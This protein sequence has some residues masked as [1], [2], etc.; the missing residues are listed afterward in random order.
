MKMGF[1][2]KNVFTMIHGK[3]R[4]L[5]F[6]YFANEYNRLSLYPDA[7]KI[8]EKYDIHIRKPYNWPPFH[9]PL[10]FVQFGSKDF[11]K[12][13]F[14]DYY[15]KL[16]NFLND[17][18][19]IESGEKMSNEYWENYNPFNKEEIVED[20]KKTLGYHER[21]K[22][23]YAIQN[24][25]IV[26]EEETLS[27][28]KIDFVGRFTVPLVVFRTMPKGNS[29]K[30]DVVIAIHGK[31]SGPDYV[32]GLTDQIDYTRA[33]GQYWAHKGHIVYAPQVN[34]DA[35]GLSMA[36]LG[37]SSIG[38]DL[39]V[40][41][42][43]ISMIRE[44]HGRNTSILV[45]GISYGAFLAELLGILSDDVQT[46]ISIGGS[47]RDTK[48]AKWLRGES[49]LDPTNNIG[50]F[51]NSLPVRY[52]FIY[53]PHVYQLLAPKPLVLSIGSHDY[54][55]YKF[56]KMPEV[57][58]YYQSI[59]FGD[60]IRINLFLGFHEA[61]PEGEYLAFEKLPVARD[62]TTSLRQGVFSAESQR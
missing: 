5:Y 39:S 57:V 35:E 20:L 8:L 43:L 31:A 38:A 1:F 62:V 19:T 47:L 56:K 22:S 37:Y 2:K 42:D 12:N 4:E 52:F 26:K 9:D 18:K 29:P 40:L 17:R 48:F 21:I 32:M 16:A 25:K 58:D 14:A 60:N 54:G 34:W 10:A 15:L 11:K 53:E 45:S 59:G 36:R 28:A 50:S 6:L 13:R 3:I 51:S 61:D 49:K 24:I 55:G 30:K 23:S 7:E 44:E 41:M 27:Y 33:F 46:I